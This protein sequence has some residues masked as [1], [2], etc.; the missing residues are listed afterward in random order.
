MDRNELLELVSSTLAISQ[1]NA[2]IS[3]A[4]LFAAVWIYSKK[5]TFGSSVYPRLLKP[6]FWFYNPPTD[7]H[8]M[9]GR[10]SFFN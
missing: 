6:W 9:Q 4:A 8:G 2:K 5:L 7:Q 1:I 10:D 3:N